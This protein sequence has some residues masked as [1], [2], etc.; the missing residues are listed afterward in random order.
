MLDLDGPSAAPPNGSP[1]TGFA[2]VTI[3]D[4]AHTMLVEVYFG[5]LL[6][7][8]TAAQLHVINGPGD[9]NP[10]DTIGPSAM[11]AP[12]LPGFPSATSGSYA[13]TFDTTQAGSYNA[14]WLTQCG[15]ST[16]FAEVELFDA[17]A[18]GRAYLNLR[19]ATFTSGEIR[20]FLPEPPRALLLGAGC[21]GLACL[22]GRRGEIAQKRSCSVQ[23]RGHAGR[24][25][26]DQCDERRA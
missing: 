20:G 2:I 7:P 19:T 23:E 5:D 4:L 1:G 18:E 24:H 21:V 11:T 15:G 9:P 26:R 13:H 14:S 17:I 10:A 16:A 22:I 12:T 6:T 8:V 3:D 25:R